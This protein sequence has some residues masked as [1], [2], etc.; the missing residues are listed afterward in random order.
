MSGQG[1]G[2]G[3][4]SYLLNPEDVVEINITQSRGLR[5]I[6]LSDIPKG[7]NKFDRVR[8]DNDFIIFK[9]LKLIRKFYTGSHFSECNNTLQMILSHLSPS[10]LPMKSLNSQLRNNKH[11]NLAI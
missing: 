5:V 9:H 10:W 2:L 7:F 4:M 6:S 8:F 11:C 3:V 1:T